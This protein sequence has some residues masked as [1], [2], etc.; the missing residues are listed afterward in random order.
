MNLKNIFKSK[1]FYLVI[2]IIIILIA[3]LVIKTPKEKKYREV[4][5]KNYKYKIRY[6]FGNTPYYIYVFPN[7]KIK[8]VEEIKEM[9]EEKYCKCYKLTG[10][11]I[12]KK[13]NINFSDETKEEVIKTL[14]Q[15]SKKVGKKTFNADKQKLTD[16][17]MKVLLAVV[18]K[19]EDSLTI[20]K[21]INYETKTEEIKDN[22]DN[23]VIKNI[24]IILSSSTNNKAVNKMAKYLNKR[25]DN[26]FNKINNKSREL[27]NNNLITNN[28]VVLKIKLKAIGVYNVSFDYIKEGQLGNER[29]Y[30]TKTY[31]F[32]TS[33]DINNDEIREGEF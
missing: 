11:I 14:A 12:Y 30:E 15:L 5:Y 28:G 4:S 23:V 32:H 8:T 2:L 31:I 3:V 24:K 27:I 10:R 6:E 20:E 16:N 19:W 1:I 17:E 9:K 26:D 13:H 25:I 21:N 29:I 7:K 22:N 18:L 33:G